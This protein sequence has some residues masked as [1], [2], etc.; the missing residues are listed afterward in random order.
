MEAERL[1]LKMRRDLAESSGIPGT[2]PD[3]PNP[4]AESDEV[5]QIMKKW[6][7]PN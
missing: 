3:I 1:V 2:I 7:T 5:D 6:L 4:T